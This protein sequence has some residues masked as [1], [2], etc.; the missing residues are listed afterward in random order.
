MSI[1]ELI[2]LHAAIHCILSATCKECASTRRVEWTTNLTIFASSI[3]LVCMYAY[4]TTQ[5]AWSTGLDRHWGITPGSSFSLRWH[6]A[7]SIYELGTYPLQNKHK[8]YYLHHIFTVVVLTATLW[9][10]RGHL[11]VCW[12][13]LAEVTIPFTCIKTALRLLRRENKGVVYLLNEKYLYVAY[14]T[15]RLINLPMCI[16]MVHLDMWGLWGN[17]ST[18]ARFSTS[19]LSHSVIVVTLSSICAAMWTLSIQWFK[20]IHANFTKVEASCHPN[21][22]CCIGIMLYGWCG[23]YWNAPLM[24]FTF[25]N[26]IAFHTHPHSNV[27]KMIDILSNLAIMTAGYVHLQDYAPWI[28]PTVGIVFVLN[29]CFEYYNKNWVVTVNAIHLVLVQGLGVYGYSVLHAHEPCNS[30]FFRCPH[31][32]KM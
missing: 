7:S 13:S 16:L 17:A 9:C 10:G 27:L 32:L 29:T 14:V 1:W 11:W 22:A 18:I 30:F 24:L 21:I 2:G 12:A 19:Q 25:I 4:H 28:V 15:S 3:L 8:R 5:L 20:K 23:V 26:G 31:L 6:L